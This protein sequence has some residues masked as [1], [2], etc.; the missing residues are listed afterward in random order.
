MQKIRSA[1]ISTLFACAAC[2]PAPEKADN[3][4][5][6]GDALECV[7]PTGPDLELTMAPPPPE[8]GAQESLSYD[9]PCVVSALGNAPFSIAL[10]CGSGSSSFDFTLTAGALEGA[11][12]T[13]LLAVG[14][15]V[16]L[17]YSTIRSVFQDAAWVAVRRSGETAPV[18]V[19]V[20]SWQPVPWFG[21]ATG[22]MSPLA[23]EFVDDT[24][25]EESAGSCNGGER[26][27]AA[28]RVSEET[29]S[30]V[31]FDRNQAMT[32]SYRITVGDA[33]YDGGN[34][35]GVNETWY[36]VVAVAHG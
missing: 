31:V 11:S 28:V 29:E 17:R 19:A 3:G 9:G 12:P 18:V 7:A 25:C 10:T 21:D 15:A 13:H 23:L 2:E 26:R 5:D 33:E 34:C 24:D 30:T 35:E 22:F 32:P 20:R 27:R 8:E 14:D 36:E 6:S 16:E 1:T 4:A